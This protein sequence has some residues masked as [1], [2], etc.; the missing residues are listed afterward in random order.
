M[1]F[2]KKGR[3][4]FILQFIKHLQGV[5]VIFHCPR[6]QMLHPAQM[7]NL[8]VVAKWHDDITNITKKSMRANPEDLAKTAEQK[9]KHI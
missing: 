7:P 9:S 3:K 2:T 1:R 6:V 4:I 8:L 5:S